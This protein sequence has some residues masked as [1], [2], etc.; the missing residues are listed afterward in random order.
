MDHHFDAYK[1]GKMWNIIIIIIIIIVHTRTA[2]PI[3]RVVAGPA[4][5]PG[6]LL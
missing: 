6:K 1:S 2:S 3:G 5:R 4:G